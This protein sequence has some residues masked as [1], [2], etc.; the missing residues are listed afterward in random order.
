MNKRTRAV[1][2]AAACALALGLAIAAAATP[3]SAVRVGGLERGDV[4]SVVF[5]SALAVAFVIYLD[6]VSHGLALIALAAGGIWLARHALRGRPRLGL[7][8]CCSS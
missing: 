2:L 3:G 1:V 8:A 7:A 5:V 4:A 6:P